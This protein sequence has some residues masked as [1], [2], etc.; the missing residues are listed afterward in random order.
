LASQEVQ[1]FLNLILS[2]PGGLPRKPQLYHFIQGETEYLAK[3]CH[4]NCLFPTFVAYG[5]CASIE[6]TATHQVAL[7]A[8]KQREKYRKSL[9]Y[10]I[11]R[12]VRK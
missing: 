8:R 12:I 7:E 4:T 10:W 3:D 1:Y 9:R 11:A 5:D 2:L 6:V